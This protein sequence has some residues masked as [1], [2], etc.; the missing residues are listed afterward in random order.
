MFSNGQETALTFRAVVT[1]ARLESS[2]QSNLRAISQRDLLMTT[3]NAE[4]RLTRLLDH[5]KHTRQ[6]LRRVHLPRMTLSAQNDVRG[7][8]AANSFERNV[9]KW[10][11]EDFESGNQSAENSPN[12]ARARSLT[13]DR[14]VDEIN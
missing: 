8:K 13:V 7:T 9:V 5:S 4:D 2:H 6:R 1:F 12:F 10:L 11:D 14:V 3:A